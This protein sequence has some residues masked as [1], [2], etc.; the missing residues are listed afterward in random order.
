MSERVNVEWKYVRIV[1]ETFR[2]FI[3]SDETEGEGFHAN[4][5]EVHSKITRVLLRYLCETEFG[6]Q[7][8][9]GKLVQ[10]TPDI[11]FCIEQKF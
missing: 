7:L 8:M 10:R 1:H 4:L 2:E 11:A 5:S 3:I 9:S 6:T